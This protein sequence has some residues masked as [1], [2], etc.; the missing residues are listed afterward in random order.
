[1]IERACQKGRG[2]GFTIAGAQPSYA[3]D[4]ALEPVHCAI[5][6]G[7]EIELQGCDAIGKIASGGLL[8]EA[9]QG[10]VRDVRHGDVMSGGCQL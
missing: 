10:D 2:D 1:M 9:S 7:L 3:P 6:V 8:R 5:E 4:L